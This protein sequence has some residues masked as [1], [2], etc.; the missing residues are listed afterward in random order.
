M[1][2]H[3]HASDPADAVDAGSPGDR[4]GKPSPAALDLGWVLGDLSY[5]LVAAGMLVLLPD[6]QPLATPVV[7]AA[8]VV[9]L[10]GCNVVLP[11]RVG[12]ASGL[13]PAFVLLLFVLPLN[14]VAVVVAA[15]P[16]MRYV[17]RK[18]PLRELPRSL[19]DNWYCVAPVLVVALAAPRHATWSEW[20]IYSA[21]FA[22][23]FLADAAI[24]AGRRTLEHKRAVPDRGT[25]LL[26][27]GVDALLTPVGL[28]AAVIAPQAP[29]AAVAVVLGVLGVIALLSHERKDRLKNEQRALHDPLTGLANRSLFDELTD[30]AARRCARTETTAALLVLDVDGFKAIND[31]HGHACGDR[32]LRAVAERLR[33][34]V[35]DADTVA[36]LGGDE[37]AVLLVDPATLSDAQALAH[38]LRR[39]FRVTMEAGEFGDFMLSASMG[40]AEFSADIAPA[41]ALATADQA[42]Y[43][44][45]HAHGEPRHRPPL[46]WN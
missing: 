3:T 11:L 46:V 12:I 29:V 36:R 2:V 24:S 37:F 42:M 6:G 38:N 27:L 21:A 33:V 18:K 5:V 16:V 4:Q 30:A 31:S 28:S 14:L 43:A 44:Q 35:R 17:L 15:G 1:R 20:P 22:A 8:V 9:F 40:T 23:Q 32:V 7:L 19:G 10:L 34:G 25:L 13:Q 41:Q 26:P 39:A 45:K